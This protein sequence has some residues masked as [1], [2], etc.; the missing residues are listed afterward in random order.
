MESGYLPENETENTLLFSS[1]PP[2]SSSAGV[3]REGGGGAAVNS[4]LR[5]SLAKRGFNMKSTGY[6]CYFPYTTEVAAGLWDFFLRL[7]GT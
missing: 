4:L 7:S 3:D 1:A 2:G 5:W 6:Q